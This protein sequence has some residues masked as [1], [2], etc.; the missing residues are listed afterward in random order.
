MAAPTSLRR[1]AVALLLASF[2]AGAPTLVAAVDSIPAEQSGERLPEATVTAVVG[3][4]DRDGVREL[5]RLG[6]LP[7]DEN[8]IGVEVVSADADGQLTRHGMAPFRRLAGV[9]EQTEGSAVADERGMVGA[10]IDEPARL[11]VWRVRGEERVLV[12]AIGTLENPRACCMTIGEVGLDARGQTSITELAVIPESASYILAADLDGDR[13]DELVVA[14]PRTSTALGR[15]PIYV[16]R[17]VGGRFSRVEGEAIG[18]PGAAFGE[19]LIP[20]GDSDGRTGDEVGLLHD[21]GIAGA[22]LARVSL[23]SDYSVRVEHAR[24]PFTGPL[25][26]MTTSEGGRLVVGTPGGA[27]SLL[28]WPARTRRIVDERSSLR[29]G[30]PVG[31][32]GS[33]SAARVLVLLN[34]AL[35]QLNDRLSGVRITRASPA[36]GALS[37]SSLFAYVGPMPGGLGGSEAFVFEGGL[38]VALVPRSDAE[39][40]I[41]ERP[42]ATLADTT[43]VGSFGPE[44][45]LLAL[46]EGGL[47]ATRAGGQLVAPAGPRPGIALS[48]ALTSTVLSG[49]AEDGRLEAA[50]T[51]AVVT[52]RGPAGPRLITRDGFTA[53]IAAPPGSRILVFEDDEARQ[54]IIVPSAG[55]ADVALPARGS[56][57]SVRL[58]VITPSGH[59]YAATW[60]VRVVNT[61]PPLQA[62]VPSATFGFSVP[63]RGQTA[64]DVGV[65]V[66][67]QAVDVASDG[68]FAIEVVAGPFPR[69]VEIR[70]TDAVGNVA[71]NTLSIVAPF[72][73]R[74]LPWVP[75]VVGLTILAGVLLYLRVPR[76]S[77]APARASGDDAVLEEI[78]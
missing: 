76:P 66:D 31:I 77:P 73:Y 21:G 58:V 37:G 40:H 64:A 47:D 75:I 29:R 16:L 1:L 45:M 71:R 18:E 48:A 56:Q 52:D 61:P 3:D 20:L 32:L 50:L 54:P 39:R 74:R 34:D 5:V 12:T 26:P 25:L 28:N 10:R 51:G 44:G 17:W 9:E 46:A 19:Q 62:S 69:E 27:S 23:T 30:V 6:P 38:L 13:T 11:L 7:D 65:T 2:V 15:T 22:L 36:V 33:G 72:D 57:Y 70:A 63:V 14:E 78:E 59:G 4:V 8:H 53:Q 35:D 68:T 41:E 67:G 24:M 49:E 55:T 60:A 42:I 43:P